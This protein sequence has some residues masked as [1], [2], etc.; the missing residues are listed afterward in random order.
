MN[1]GSAEILPLSSC[2][3]QKPATFVQ[4][5][6]TPTQNTSALYCIVAF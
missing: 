2:H 5:V 4:P 3:C 1:D 6:L